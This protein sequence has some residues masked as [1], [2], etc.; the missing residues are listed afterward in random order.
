MH[1]F[2]GNALRQS[3]AASSANPEI[4]FIKISKDM[5]RARAYV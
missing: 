1:T 2:C 5:P 4:D 3:V